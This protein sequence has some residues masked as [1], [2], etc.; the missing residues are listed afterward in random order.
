MGELF[1]YLPQYD[2]QGRIIVGESGQPL[3]TDE[4][5]DTG[6]NVNADWTGG[7]TTALSWK[8]LTLSAALDIRKGGYMFSGI[9]LPM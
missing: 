2:E 7:I 6:K 5:Q 1:T 4:V 8:G 9:R 3:L